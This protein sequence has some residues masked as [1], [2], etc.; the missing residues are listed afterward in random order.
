MLNFSLGYLIFSDILSYEVHHAR[1]CYQFPWCQ[2][3]SLLF[4]YLLVIRETNLLRLAQIMVGYGSVGYCKDNRGIMEFKK[5]LGATS[6]EETS[7][8]QGF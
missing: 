5:K 6:L 7:L 1:V 3:K 8:E 4:K 2:C